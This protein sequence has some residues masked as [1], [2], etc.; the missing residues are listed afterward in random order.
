MKK[1]FLLIAVTVAIIL[2]IFI[3]RY[4]GQ[5]TGGVEKAEKKP[6]YWTDPMDPQVRRPGPGKSNMGMDLVPVYSEETKAAG[7]S[8]SIY[9]SPAI[10]NNLG[11]RTAPVS[12]E[13]LARGIE[14]VGYVEPN[15]KKISHINSC[16]KISRTGLAGESPVME[17]ETSPT[18]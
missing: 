16:A 14:T 12:K 15:E 2:G 5:L 17:G 10:V 4:S 3:G 7:T 1:V 8:E 11:V 18:M 6:L 13:T 9:I